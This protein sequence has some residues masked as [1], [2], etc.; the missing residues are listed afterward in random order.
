MDYKTVKFELSNEQVDNL[1]QY[2]PAF[3]EEISDSIKNKF[4]AKTSNKHKV[5][6]SR[7][8][9][10]AIMLAAALLS[11]SVL[12]YAGVFDLRNLY[13]LVF[14]ERGEYVSQYASII[15]GGNESEGIKLNL[16]SAVKDETKL[17]VF[18]SLTDLTASNRFSEC[19]DLHEWLLDHGNGGTCS[20]VDFN[21][22]TQ[23]AT[24]MITSLGSSRNKTAT[25]TIKSFLET[26]EFKHG[27]VEKDIDIISLLNEDETQTVPFKQFMK[28]GYG[29]GGLSG[30]NSD[31]RSYMESLNMLQPDK[32]SVPL[33]EIDWTVISNIGF[34]DNEFHI[35]LLTDR[36]SNV[37]TIHLLDKNGNA[38]YS[39]SLSLMYGNN[40]N[41]KITGRGAF[42][43]FIFR[44]IN[45]ASQ[46][47][48]LTISM[49][50]AEYGAFH[51]GD[52]KAA[53]QIPRPMTKLDIPVN[54]D[55]I[56]SGEN[57]YIDKMGISPLGISINYRSQG[58]GADGRMRD[59]AF[60]TY[61]D[62]TITNMQF[63]SNSAM[64]NNQIL[65]FSFPILEIEQI[66]S[67]NINGD[68]IPI[69]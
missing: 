17:I 5:L 55:L 58:S 41:S 51:T 14:G 42:N 49:D 61:K 44:D 30:R 63:I 13:N 11:L 16:I 48:D 18:F 22:D 40:E 37:M 10:F 69:N 9:V 52:W 67:V 25:L 6:P 38:K 21:E 28:E 60:V 32:L 3:S 53:F 24:F 57:V 33:S 64:G 46:L 19:M 54:R 4:Y 62:G 39:T 20:M 23:T 26:L 27:L 12:A 2:A 15:D 56:L 47:K 8:T 34:V 31:D 43:E 35:Q 7:K 65:E 29:A 1:M 36:F 45:N 68:E 66:A 50:V 59:T